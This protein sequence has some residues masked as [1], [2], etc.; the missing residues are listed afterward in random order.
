MKCLFIFLKI[1]L[2]MYWSTILQSIIQHSSHKDT[3]R[4]V[5]LALV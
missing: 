5:E 1:V 2:H 4:D 3:A